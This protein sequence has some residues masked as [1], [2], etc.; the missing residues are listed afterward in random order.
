MLSPSRQ[1]LIAQKFMLSPSKVKTNRAET[2]YLGAI[3]FFL[4]AI[5]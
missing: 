1:N 2:D 4:L 3:S 5:K